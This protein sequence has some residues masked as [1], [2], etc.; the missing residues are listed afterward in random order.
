MFIVVM[1]AIVEWVY[2]HAQLSGRVHVNCEPELNLNWSFRGAV[3]C[4]NSFLPCSYQGL[5]PTFGDASK[6]FMISESPSCA[7]L[8]LNFDHACEHECVNGVSSKHV[9]QMSRG[10]HHLCS[11]PNL[12]EGGSA[13][14]APKFFLPAAPIGST[15]QGSRI[16]RVEEY[17]CSPR[18]RRA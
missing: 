2:R 3:V 14:C 5:W 12:A 10:G 16:W 11:Q 9:T 7:R 6:M 17:V 4:F 8:E 13:G 18:R 1:M 15:Q